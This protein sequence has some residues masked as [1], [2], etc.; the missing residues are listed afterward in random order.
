MKSL[1]GK[2]FVETKGIYND[3]QS[4]KGEKGDVDLKIKIGDYED[5]PIAHKKVITGKVVNVCAKV[6]KDS[7]NFVY[8][9]MSKFPSPY[10][11]F[12]ET[13][14]FNHEIEIQEG[15][16][17]YFHF[18]SLNEK[19]LFTKLPS[20]KE[21]HAIEYGDVF[22]YVRGSD[23]TPIAGYS[24][25]GQQY[26]EAVQEVDYFGG[27]RKMV[28]SKSGIVID[29]APK[30]KKRKGVLRYIGKNL[31]PE[32]RQ[33]AKVGDTVL[34]APN[35][36]RKVLVEGEEYY[37][38]KSNGMFAKEVNGD[39]IPY[40]EFVLLRPYFGNPPVGIEIPD[41]HSL[42]KDTGEVLFMGPLVSPEINIGD[43][44]HYQSV[45][46]STYYDKEKNQMLVRS[47]LIYGKGE[48]KVNVI[49]NKPFFSYL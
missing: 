9:Y 7:K 31:G 30:T 36:N 48:S 42:I 8:N 25:I 32:H 38:T 24:L 39:T 6:S 3:T 21:L 49:K 20:G 17:V 15:D 34:L 43:V 29:A 26:D 4:I 37:V 16:Q 11:V 44:V 40:G 45:G 22:C 18:N 1:Y 5:A 41:P 2:V 23:I 47:P 46:H 28:V 27:K 14:V 12:E 35:K 10:D 19:T 33:D 13:Y